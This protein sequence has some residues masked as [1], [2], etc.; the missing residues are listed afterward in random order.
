MNIV[1]ALK[2]IP[3]MADELPLNA[4]GSNLDFDEVDFV[5]NEFDE[6]ALEQAVLVKEKSG[7]AVTALGVDLIEALDDVLYTALAKGADKAI[8]IVG[9]FEPGADSHTQAAWLAAVIRDLSPD[10]VL[11]G[12]QAANDLDGQIGPMLAAH[13]DLPYVG[14]VT[15]LEVAQ[16][17][18]K[19]HK[20]FAG[21]VVADIE[22]DL[23]C[24]AG[25]QAAAK[26]PRYA[27]IS[28]IRQ[29]AKTAQ[30]AEAEA[31]AAGPDAG[32]TLRRMAKPVATGRA[33]MLAG[34]A[35][36]VAAKIIDIL[37]ERGLL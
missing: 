26:P 32:V 29:I 24:V 11:T 34:D 27:P 8:K 13:L 20:E 31:A 2:Q 19:V 22:V 33:D 25:I 12:V 7:G 10:L 1:V 4:Q 21:G 23:P 9:D 3:S 17:V 36:Q 16:G 6:H 15:G 30:I 28:K 37:T 5:L 18:A 14:V 35:K